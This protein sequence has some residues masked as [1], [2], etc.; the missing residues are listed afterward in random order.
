MTDKELEET[1]FPKNFGI[2]YMEVFQYF[3]ENF[4]I[5]PKFQTN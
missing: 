4:K 1:K 2:C 3:L 5:I